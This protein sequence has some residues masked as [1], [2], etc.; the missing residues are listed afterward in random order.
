MVKSLQMAKGVEE[1]VR[2]LL[3]HLLESGKVSG[4]FTLRQLSENKSGNAISYSLMTTKEATSN[5]SPFYP[6]MPRNAGGLVGVLT[7]KGAVPAPVA[8]VLRPCE[9]RAFVELVK[10]NRGDM[11]NLVIISSTCGGVFPSKMMANGGLENELPKY[12]ET[13]SKNEVPEGIRSACKGCTEFV[14]YNADMTVLSVGGGDNTKNTEILLNSA[15][16]EELAAEKALNGKIIDQELPAKEL[17]SLRAKRETYKKEQ[18]E[19]LGVESLNL[20]GMVDIF[21]KCIGC[22]GCRSACPIC[23]CELCTFDTQNAQSGLSVTELDRKGGIRMPPGT[24]YYHMTRLPHVSISCVGCGS[25]EDACPVEIPLWTLF[26][27]VGEDVQGIFNYVPGKDPEEEI[28]IK[29][30][31]L[32]EYT[33]VED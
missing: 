23:Y 1:S 25:C 3:Q 30:F 24:V 26:Q 27:K 15:K 33:E 29:T 12:W 20:K 32:D 22:R 17:D 6:V 19:A 8:I 18:I 7:Q 11:E 31:E 13:I 10:R 21:G 2:E 4:V 5:I 14:P 28:P 16:A 9:T